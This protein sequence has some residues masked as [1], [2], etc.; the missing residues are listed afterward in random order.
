MDPET[1]Q[2]Q[3]LHD[4]EPIDNIDQ[5]T[6]GNIF[7]WAHR[8]M[9]DRWAL[10][11]GC[12]AL[13][14]IYEIIASMFLSI[15]G[16]YLIGSFVSFNPL[17]FLHSIFVLGPLSVGPAYIAARTF[18][19]QNTSIS[20]IWIGFSR[21][22]PIVLIGF[23]I[24]A[25]YLIA[26]FPMSAVLSMSERTAAGNSA[27]TIL[28]VLVFGIVLLIGSIYMAI[29]LYFATLLCADPL[30]PKLSAF[31]SISE[32][33]RITRKSAWT[34]FLTAIVISLI[35]VVCAACVFI[36]LILYGLPLTYGA[37]GAVYVVLTHQ[38]GIIPVQGYDT[39]PF[40]DYDLSTLDTDLCP[41]CGARVIRP[42]DGVEG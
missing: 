3:T 42:A 16:Q 34:L 30:G 7:R 8:V 12:A 4:L 21:W 37:A 35:A 1:R 41:E 29:R 40:C 5:I 26:M 32:S 33:W 19:G 24:Q 10:L 13:L 11:V 23:I 25:G 27:L 20:D 15:V 28:I 38:S 17:E 39:C 6:F 14:V 31:D 9:G 22:A 18:R 36:P 2:A